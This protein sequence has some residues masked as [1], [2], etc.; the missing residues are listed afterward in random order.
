MPS[1]RRVAWA[2]IR[3][4]AVS[5]AAV[6]IL[7]VLFYLLTGG[8]LLRQTATLYL[9]IP[10]TAGL[11]AGSLVRVDGINVGKVASVKLSGSN[12]PDRVVQV[13]LTVRHEYLRT[14]TTDST[15]EISSDTLIGDKFVDVTSGRSPDHI[16]PDAEMQFKGSADMM[17]SLDL[18]QFEAELRTVAATLD[19]IEGGQS[20]MG[21]FILG[22]RM[23]SDLLRRL[24][25]LQ[26]AI[27]N[28]VDTTTA[29]GGALYTDTLY[30][31]VSAPL[32]ELD[33]T[34]AR[35]QSGPMMR[36][37][38]QYEQ[39]VRTAADLR[40]SI[41][42]LRGGAFFQSDAMYTEWNRR[43]ESLIMQV[44]RMNADPMFSSSAAYDNLNGWAQQMERTMRDFREHPQKYLRLKVF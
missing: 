12:S 38:A 6:T 5:V 23:Y 37:T 40:K 11:V 17:K 33:R 26:N 44:D 10:D 24:Q 36:D 15:A 35:I 43:V 8:T 29:V 19:D 42:D 14:I 4:V 20:P 2:K 18:R 28:A 3:V 21:Q 32:I 25:Q 27:R 13:I 9:Y 16:L 34:L 7:S 39:L 22:D 30:R 41:S 31:D 1:A